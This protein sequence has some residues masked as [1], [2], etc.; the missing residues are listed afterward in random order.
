MNTA[1]A[2]PSRSA[3]TR[4]STSGGRR[5]R[6]LLVSN[7][8]FHYRVSNYNY[9]ARRFREEGYEFLV[10]ANEIQKNNPYPMEFDFKTVPFGFLNYKREIEA[11]QPD[12]VILFLHLKNVFIWPL[13]HWL[14]LRGIKVVY[15]NKGVNLEVRNPSWRNHLFYYV[16]SRCDGIILY[17]QHN[18]GDIQPKNRHKVFVASNTINLDALPQVHESREAIKREFGIPFR[19]VVLFVGRMRTV[20]KVEHLIEAFNGIADPDVGCVIVGDQMDYDLKSMIKSDQILYLGEIFDPKNEQV[21]KL[22]KASDIFCIP[23]DVGLGLNEAF[24][25]GLPVVTEDGLQPPEIHYLTP[26]RNGFIVPEGDIAGL[27][28]KLQLLLRDDALRASFSSA[29]RED[30]ARDASIETMFRGFIDCV[31]RLAPVAPATHP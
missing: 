18:V 14:K 11:I 27:R 22:F 26:G 5:R 21:S 8:V 20:K 4:A 7:K 13:I 3:I 19:K 1:S 10:R 2:A 28:E 17:C 23:G 12:V 31:R 29:A 25:W 16:H 24:H 6:V 9:F 30:I 15:W